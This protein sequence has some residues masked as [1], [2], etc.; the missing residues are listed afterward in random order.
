MEAA[1][2]SAAVKLGRRTRRVFGSE[3]WFVEVD[4]QVVIGNDLVAGRAKSND[5]SGC[6]RAA[7]DAHV[8]DAVEC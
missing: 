7:E 4:R 2:V 1:A 8:V 3:R 6:R 5:A